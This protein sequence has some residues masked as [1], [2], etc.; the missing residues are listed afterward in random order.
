MSE[1]PVRVLVAKPGLDGHDVGAKLIC[2]AL[3]DAGMEVIYTGLRQSPEAIARAARDEDVDVVGLSILSG[4]HV[5]LCER[6]VEELRAAGIMDCATLIVGGNVPPRDHEALMQ[7]GVAAVFPTGASFEDIVTF[8]RGRT[9]RAA[10]PV[11]AAVRTSVESREVRWESGIEI[12]PVYAASD[13]E[14]SGGWN[15]IGA[16][17]EYPFTRG[18]HPL[19][20]R[21][22][23]W[24]MRQYSGFGTAAETHERFLYLIAHGQT[25]L[26][27][28]FDLPTQCGLDSDDPM[29]AGEVGR[30]G[31]AVDTLADIEEAFEGIDLNRT[32]VSLTINGAAAPIMAMFFAMA[33]KRG[34]E[35]GQLRGTAQNDILKEFVGRGTWIFPVEDSVRLVGDTIAFCAE[36]V[37]HYNPVSVCGYHIRESGATPAQEM[38]YGL[39]IAFAYVDHMMSRGLAVDEVARGLSFNFDIHG[40]LWE[41]VAK[42]RAGRRLYARIL[43]ERYGAKDPRAMQL[44]MIA[45]GG[46]AGLTI[47]QPENNIARGAYY[48]LA[49]ALSGTQTMALCSYDEAYTIPSEHAARLSLRTMQILM[50]EVGACDTVDPLAGSWFVESTTNEMESLIERI[51]EEISSQGGIIPAIADGRVQAAVNRSAYEREKQ[52]RSGAIKKVGLNCCR[53]EEQ[54]HPV[55]MHPYREEEARRQI[56]RLE[57]VRRERDGAA[58]AS[59]LRRVR[60]AARAHD[61]VMPPILEAVSAYASVGEVCATLKDELGTYV[62]RVRL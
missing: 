57:R 33:K 38:A 15:G 49:S 43:R 59:L 60:E 12:K 45:G 17:G 56:A 10:A 6:V 40:N 42:F 29:A 26:N 34:F 20:Y 55:E 30:V 35:L 13:V 47:E 28:A 16:P 58:V 7:L 52:I 8:I 32:T 22:R 50:Y 14:A 19:M 53:E 1:R 51:L 31:M 21:Q 4:A 23:P 46:G 62:E 41:Q 61:N 2:R 54:P 18:I 48:A 25:G 9:A 37:P 24:T 5:P 3:M 44:R 36:H 11:A 39:A 27:V